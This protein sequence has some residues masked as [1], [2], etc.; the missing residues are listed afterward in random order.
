MPS[1][2]V[3]VPSGLESSLSSWYRK[4]G[5]WRFPFIDVI[6][7]YKWGNF[8]S[9]FRA[10]PL[11][12]VSQNNQLKIILTPK[13]PIMGRHILVSYSHVFRWHILVLWTFKMLGYLD[14]FLF[15]KHLKRFVIFVYPLLVE[16]KS[17]L[18]FFKLI[19]NEESTIWGKTLRI[20]LW[21]EI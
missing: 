20:N 7:S 13:K 12:A 16:K 2:L 4:R 8:Y 10:F 21:A 1:P 6:F 15:V 19:M 18:L 9:V 5:K 3:R 17:T 14:K 11:S